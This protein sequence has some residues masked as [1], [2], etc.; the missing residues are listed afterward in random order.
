MSHKRGLGR[1]L[2]A[3][4]P[5][6]ALPPVEL[7]AEAGIRE[8]AINE[9]GPNPRQPRQLFDEEAL[10]E[11]A[12][13]IQEHG[14]IQ[15]V[16]VTRNQDGTFPPYHL[17][18]GER[19]WRAARLAGLEVIPAIVKETTPQQL[20]E[21]ALVENLQRA[22]LNPLEAAAA[23]QSLIDDFGLTQ[24]E[25]AR[26]VGKSRV[27][28]TNAVRLLRLPSPVKEA[29][30][31]NEI[32]EGHA[33]ALL[34]LDDPDIQVQALEIIRQRGLN[35]RQT[36]ELVR[37][38]AAAL[39]AAG[40]A[41]EDTSQE[42]EMMALQTAALEERFRTVLGTKV[43]LRRGRRGGRLIIHFYSEEE[44]QHIYELIVGEGNRV[45]EDSS[46]PQ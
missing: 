43:N 44:L 17:V 21:L 11:L 33:R 14:L 13:S 5:P 26:R 38:M 30:A 1:G 6:S 45:R 2:G 41:E 22:D 10:A 4:I 20:L 28:V 3:L 27:A 8:I 36:E 25:V 37:R 15:P 7:E 16:I 24:A 23:Y 9:I 18:T 32:S 34:G 35:V 31:G 29:L 39:A 42:D 19:R 46:H 12:A 40:E